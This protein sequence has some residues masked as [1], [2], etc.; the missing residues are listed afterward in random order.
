MS[1][2]LPERIGARLDGSPL[3]VMLDVDGTLAPIAPTPEQA[4]IPPATLDV[5]RRI[6][7][8]PSVTLAFISGRA[9]M[10]T[11]RMTGVEGAWVAG[12]HG[13]E[14]REPGGTIAVH[15]EV[16][17]FEDDITAAATRL[18]RDLAGVPGAFVENKRWTISVHYRQVAD[19]A[20]QELISRAETSAKVHGLRLMDG[21]KIV[22][23][24][25]PVDVNKGTAVTTLLQR[26]G[27]SAE[28]G[29]ALYAGDDRTDEDA[30]RALRAA[31]P[32]AITIRVAHGSPLSTTA[33]F[34]LDRPEEL[35]ELLE[36]VA[37][38]RGVVDE[39]R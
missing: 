2:S 37:T 15:P 39:A 30:F 23:L 35:R 34:E 5:L 18:E 32:N 22:E 9:A 14:F 31:A 38:R 13:G 26:A 12:N 25:P 17:K 1:A 33:E 11:W 4:A 29:A 21:K 16:L 10:D 20:Q 6:A 36:W 24:R 3:L 27:V 28:S 7:T 19:A 8:L